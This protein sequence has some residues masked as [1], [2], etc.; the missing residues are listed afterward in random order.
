MVNPSDAQEMLEEHFKQ[1][2]PEEFEK[3]RQRYVK[4]GSAEPAAK[5]IRRKFPG[6]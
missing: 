4:G 3:R 5:E 2:S 1:L 6:T